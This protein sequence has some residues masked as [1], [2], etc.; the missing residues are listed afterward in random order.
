MRFSK[1]VLAALFA[2]TASLAAPTSAQA[3]PTLSQIL[4]SL[5]PLHT[6]QSL[7]GTATFGAGGGAGD[8]ATSALFQTFT[9]TQ[10]GSFGMQVKFAGNNS[11]FGFFNPPASTTASA[12]GA[13]DFNAVFTVVGSNGW[14]GTNVTGSTTVLSHVSAG[15]AVADAGGLREKKN[16]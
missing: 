1:F 4:T 2:T 6:S 12:P 15:S 14:D 7:I 16:K 10:N 13:A 3:E 8:P 9:G 5:Y 11:T